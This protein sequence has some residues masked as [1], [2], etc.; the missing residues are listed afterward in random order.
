MA[1]LRIWTVHDGLLACVAPLGLAASVETALVID[2]DPQGPAYPGPAS[3]ADL[4][5][6]GPRL[7]DLQP[8]R[9]GLAVLRNGGISEGHEEVVEA[10]CAGWPHVVLRQPRSAFAE[11]EVPVIPALSGPLSHSF[12][13]PHVAQRTGL[14]QASENAIVTLPRLSRSNLAGLLSGTIRPRSRW[15]RAWKPV[16]E[17]PW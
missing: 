3:L 11:A 17:M 13:Q 8:Q 5:E 6:R 2:M 10:L 1:V 14:G 12:D 9:S 4:V 16:W 7:A 15:V